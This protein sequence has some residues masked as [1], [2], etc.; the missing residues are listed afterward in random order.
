MKLWLYSSGDGESN[1]A[2]DRA[3]L[4]NLGNRRPTFTFI[5]SAFEDH[6][7]DYD[8]FIERFSSYAYINFNLIHADRPLLRRD[9]FRALNSDVVY[10]SGGNTFHFL[11]N[12]R[13]ADLLD[14][15]KYFVST[16]GLLAGHSAGSILMTPSIHTASFPHFDRDDNEVGINDWRG[17]KLVPFEF[18]PHYRNSRRYSHELMKHSRREVGVVYAAADGAGIVVLQR[19]TTFFGS[20]WGFVGGHRFRVNWLK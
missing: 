8:E 17:L 4:R 18:F 1:E 9:R 10:L 11:Y 16:G 5:P 12:L 6:L 2:M 3:L 7:T 14:D 19:Q 15:L 13:R 20:I